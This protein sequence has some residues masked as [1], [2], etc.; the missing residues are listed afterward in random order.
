LTDWPFVSVIVISYNGSDV[1]RGCLNTLE[2]NDYPNFELIVVDNGSTDTLCEIV[3]REY[4]RVRLVHLMPNR[5][6]AGGMN[7]GLKAARGEI[8]I[9]FNDDTESTPNLIT[10]M[11]RP[12]M[13]DSSIGITGCKIL[14]PDRKTLQHAGGVILPNG[15]THHIGYG[16]EDR[17]QYEQAR[18]ADYVTGCALAI[19]RGLFEQL[20]LYDDRYYPTYFEEVEFAWRARRAG[21]RILYVPSAVLY[22]LESKTEGRLSPAMLY[23]YNKSRWRFVLKNFPLRQWPAALQAEWQWLKTLDRK[24]YFRPLAK[25][26]LATLFRLPWI[27]YDRNHRFLPMPQR[28]SE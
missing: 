4:P 6:Y 15:L 8:L 26:Y 10:E 7:E 19:R 12:L 2:A 9:P 28:N 18:E 24:Q 3:E 21:H 16:E 25:A 27:L 20:G 11:I 1:I 14:Y 5:G 22:H 13:E 17:G 23:R